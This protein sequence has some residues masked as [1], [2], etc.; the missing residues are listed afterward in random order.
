MLEKGLLAGSAEIWRKRGPGHLDRL[1]AFVVVLLVADRR[2][3]GEQIQRDRV[4]AAHARR[5]DDHIGARVIRS[6][7][8]HI[9]IAKSIRPH[10]PEIVEA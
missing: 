7:L 2:K 10:G 1:R 5:P 4:A 3:I 6:G 8:D 9:V